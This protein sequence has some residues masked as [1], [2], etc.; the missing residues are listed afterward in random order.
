V[1]VIGLAILPLVVAV[2]LGAVA[3]GLL[4]LEARPRVARWRGAVAVLGC[5]GALV[6]TA[7][8]IVA[9]TGD[10]RAVAAWWR[11]PFSAQPSFAAGWLALAAVAGLLLFAA[12]SALSVLVLAVVGS[13]GAGWMRLT[14]GEAG[15]LVG[16]RPV[17]WSV[18][19]ATALLC[20]AE[21]LA[22]RG[23]A[24][25]GLTE[26]LGLTALAAVGASAVA[27]GLAHAAHGARNVALKTIDG[28]AWGAMFAVSQSLLLPFCSHLAFNAVAWLR[29][30]RAEAPT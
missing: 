22:W 28:L 17:W 7:A 25:T 14:R 5:G 3:S 18:V 2:G 15:R 13:R 23:Y 16:A 29:L 21:E 1:A 9:A 24:I 12:E 19:P 6:G 10:P 8:A 4:P 20:A 30:A 27:F 11:P 26:R